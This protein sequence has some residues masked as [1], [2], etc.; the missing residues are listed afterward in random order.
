MLNINT[1]KKNIS[2]P[3]SHDSVMLTSNGFME[4]HVSYKE[5]RNESESHF[6]ATTQAVDFGSREKHAS[7]EGKIPNQARR[8]YE[9]KS[10]ELAMSL[11]SN[12]A[13]GAFEKYSSLDDEEEKGTLKMKLQINI[14]YITTP[15]IPVDINEAY[16]TSAELLLRPHQHGEA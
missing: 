2:S 12:Q 8:K 13:Y 5:E 6:V 3:T 4:K 7:N 11:T 9:N 15:H 1:Q 10:E 14:A 16:A